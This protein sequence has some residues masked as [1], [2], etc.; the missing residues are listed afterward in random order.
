MLNLLKELCAASGVSSWEHPVR[1]L[2]R[3]KAAP[4]KGRQEHRQ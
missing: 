2:I 4:Y 3:E 1:E